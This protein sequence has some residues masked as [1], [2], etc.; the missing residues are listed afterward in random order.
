MVGV[1]WRGLEVLPL[2]S[3]SSGLSWLG[4]ELLHARALLAVIRLQAVGRP[5][6]SHSLPLGSP[7]LVRGMF[8]PPEVHSLCV[9]G[10]SRFLR[11]LEGKDFVISSLLLFCSTHLVFIK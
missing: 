3:R 4:E 5:Q 1:S 10:A 7:L 8:L 2:A 9:F 11:V 6:P